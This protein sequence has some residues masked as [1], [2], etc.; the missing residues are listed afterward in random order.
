MFQH[1][2]TVISSSSLP[3]MDTGYPN[4]LLGVLF[5]LCKQMP[6]RTSLGY[7]Y[8]IH[9][10]LF[11]LMQCGLDISNAVKHTHN[12]TMAGVWAHTHA[13]TGQQ[14][15]TLNIPK[16]QVNNHLFLPLQLR[17]R[18]LGHIQSLI[19]ILSIFSQVSRFL[20]HEVCTALSL[21]Q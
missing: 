21:S 18:L 3:T 8:F 17:Y 14:F 12:N 19:V 6:G 16:A 13:L 9:Q 2:C 11:H 10:A 1:L 4:W 20:F 7:N 5:D 15:T